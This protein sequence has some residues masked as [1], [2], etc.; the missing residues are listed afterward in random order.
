MAEV[1][2]QFVVLDAQFINVICDVC[3]E[4]VVLIDSAEATDGVNEAVCGCQEKKTSFVQ[5]FF[6]AI[7]RFF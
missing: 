6:S 5:N 2:E 3:H 4:Q 7:R 1:E